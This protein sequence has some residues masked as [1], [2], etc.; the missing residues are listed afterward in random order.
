MHDWILRTILCEW[1][2]RRVTLSVYTFQKDARLVAEQVADLKIPLRREWGPSVHINEVRGP[3]PAEEG[4][5][6]L[7]IEMQ[8]GDLITILAGSFHEHV[9][10]RPG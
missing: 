5:Q 10:G 1:E 2:E 9:E 3:L 4:R 8:T 6:R 7:E